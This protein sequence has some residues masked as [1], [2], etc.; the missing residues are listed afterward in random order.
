M[1]EAAITLDGWYALHEFRSMDWAS[2]K[3]VS[4]EER[5]AAVEEFIT[6]LDKLNE[7]DV[8]KTGAHAFYAIVGQKADFMIMTLRE[9][10]DELQEVEAAFNKLA[11]ADFTIPTYSYVSVVE[12]SNYLAGDS[13]DDPYTQQHHLSP[14]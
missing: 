13:N 10:M 2:W 8:A 5:Q 4:A 9:T 3:L 12:L 6:Y 11:I 1:N 7:A 14:E